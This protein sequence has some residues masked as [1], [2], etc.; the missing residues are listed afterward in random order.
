M[1]TDIKIYDAVYYTPYREKVARCG[2]VV[3]TEKPS[4][5]HIEMGNT[6]LYTIFDPERNFKLCWGDKC[7]K[8]TKMEGY[9]AVASG[10]YE[11][12]G[13]V[14]QTAYFNSEVQ[15]MNWCKDGNLKYLCWPSSI[16]DFRIVP[17]K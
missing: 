7:H 2:I 14:Y 12:M 17:L 9:K 13:N 1:S 10:F 4:E 15:C 11:I 8:V 16:C 6:I 5:H 3:G